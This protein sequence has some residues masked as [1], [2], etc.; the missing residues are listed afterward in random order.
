ME[1]NIDEI[2]EEI[3][4]E[5]KQQY[6]EYLH[7]KFD[8]VSK[9][10][11]DETTIKTV[12]FITLN[13]FFAKKLITVSNDEVLELTNRVIH[14]LNNLDHPEAMKLFFTDESKEEVKPSNN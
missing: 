10:S 11:C 9:K 3:A 2:I 1:K 13:N 4:E 5:G 8:E 12:V 7:K 14:N 6:K